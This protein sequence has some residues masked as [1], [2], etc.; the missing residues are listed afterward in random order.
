M[1]ANHTQKQGSLTL[2]A[3]EKQV[4][5]DL[6]WEGPKSKLGYLLTRARHSLANGVL[7]GDLPS[8]RAFKV[9]GSWGGMY[10]PLKQRGFG[11]RA[12]LRRAGEVGP[13]VS[14]IWGVLSGRGFWRAGVKGNAEMHQ[15]MP[16]GTGAEKTKYL[17]RRKKT[18]K[19]KIIGEV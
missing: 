13:R 15:L 18:A 16:A 12:L 10:T 2:G 8:K 14:S 17:A 1:F 3:G 7:K 11:I 6:S 4:G 19:L 9:P 5:G